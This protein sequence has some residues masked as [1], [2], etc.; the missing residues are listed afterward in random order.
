MD[1]INQSEQK[2]LFSEKLNRDR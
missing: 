2:G 1:A